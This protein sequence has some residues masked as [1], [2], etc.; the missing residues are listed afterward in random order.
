[1]DLTILF[2]KQFASV[3]IVQWEHSQ[4]VIQHKLTITTQTL[5]RERNWTLDVSVIDRL[6]CSA[7]GSC[8]CS[9]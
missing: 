1:V 2:E 7:S 6:Y 8:R 9:V 3:E 4:Y 5:S